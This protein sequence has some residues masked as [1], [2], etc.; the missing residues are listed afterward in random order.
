MS[1]LF[2]G[3]LV[4]TP[5]A[6]ARLPKPDQ[7]HETVLAIDLETQTL[8]CKKG[9]G[10]KPFLLDWNKDTEFS[11]D[12]RPV[13]ARELTQGAT[14]LIRYRNLSFRNPLLEKVIWTGNVKKV[15]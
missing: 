1:F 11:K 8:V 3:F 14:I 7:A 9:P 2:V 15:P 5:N 6:Q 4:L 10:A 12:G 13:S